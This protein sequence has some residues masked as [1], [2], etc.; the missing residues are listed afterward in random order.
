LLTLPPICSR[1][2]YSAEAD[3]ETCKHTLSALAAMSHDHAD[4]VRRRVF[5]DLVSRVFGDDHE[6]CKLKKG[7]SHCLYL[8][9]DPRPIV[10][11][12]ESIKSNEAMQPRS[13]PMSENWTSSY[14]T[15]GS[16]FP[17]RYDEQ[18]IEH[19]TAHED[20]RNLVHE[21]FSPSFDWNED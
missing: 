15:G 12:L 6:E 8:M 16:P 5:Q 3:L 10:R 13:D 20:L 2:G 9:T 14:E 4:V 21:A 18:H 11:R 19:V 1:L 17:F 7:N